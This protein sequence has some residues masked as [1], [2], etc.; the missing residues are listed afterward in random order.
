[1]GRY[2]EW[3][4]VIDRYPE[5]NTLSGADEFSS[6][7]IVYSE[8]FVD[9]ILGNNFTVPFSNNNMTV[10]DLS[11]DMTYYRAGRFKFSNAIDVKSSFFETVK[12]LNMGQIIMVDPDGID[13]AHPKK[14]LGIF[15][16]T[17]SYHSAFGMQAAEEWHIDQDNIDDDRNA[18]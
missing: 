5:L 14:Q 6:A 11:I 16:S 18:T 10:K 1:M 13:L 9:G 7:Y 17:Q 3:D 12:M 2:I 8:A 4:D 15:S